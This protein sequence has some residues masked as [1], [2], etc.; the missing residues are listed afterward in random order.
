MTTTPFADTYETYFDRGWHVIPL[1]ARAK[2][3][4]PDGFTGAAAP[5]S[6]WPDLFTW[7]DTRPDANIA[8]RLP[9]TVIGVDVDAY[10]GKRG[11]ETIAEAEARWG[12]LPSTWT[13][14]SRTDGS[15][16]RLFTVPSGSR[17]RGELGDGV[18]IVQFSHRYVVAWPSIHPEGRTYRWITFDGGDAEGPPDIDDLPPLPQEWIDGLRTTVE[19]LDPVLA[20]GS[21]GLVAAALT[22]GQPSPNV[23]SRLQRA[24]ADLS[25]SA[26]SRFAATRGHILML[27]TLGHMGEPGVADAI[28]TLFHAYVPAVSAARQGGARAAESEFRRAVNR[29]GPRL[30]QPI[31]TGTSADNRPL[32]ELAGL[33][34]RGVD[35]KK[36]SESQVTQTHNPPPVAEDKPGSDRPR[37][38]LA[39]DLEPAKQPEWIGVRWLPKAA[40]TI[41]VGDE[42][43]GKSLFWVLVAAAVTTGRA[44]PACGI[45]AREPGIVLVVV[46]ED[47]WSTVVRPRLEVAG[48]DIER[49]RV[50]CTEK[51]GS[52]APVFPRDIHLIAEMPEA[53]TLIVVDAWLDTVPAGLKVSDPQGARQALHPWK[54]LATTTGAAT[55]LLTHTNRV[56]TANAR[57]RYGATSEL[58]KKARMTLYAQADDEGRLVVGPEKANST[59]PAAAGMFTIDSIQHFEPTEDDDGTVG[60]LR[61]VGASDQTARELLT[62]NYEAAVAFGDDPTPKMISEGWLRD[63]LAVEGPDAN[64]AELKAAAKRQGIPE[65]TIQRAAKAIGVVYGK[66]GFGKD[67][68]VT[69]SLPANMSA[70]EGVMRDGDANVVPLSRGAH[71]AHGAHAENPSSEASPHVRHMRAT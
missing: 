54:E 62:A 42:G 6:S 61:Y 35:D 3:P 12:A 30:A 50:I 18:E 48:A 45:P 19:P 27:L 69:W 32:F 11:A 10:G 67:A 37:V 46:T 2:T 23:A 66:S 64:G 8:I 5:M 59:K 55:M 71:G 40:T 28:T 44:L 21:G 4:P 49:I 39:A 53:P 57:D 22:G 33:P 70:D 14:T 52:G 13:S 58:R 29:A 20:A 25:G 26:G 47:D 15:G 38:W 31:S 63:Y 9:D 1:P 56:A 43:I 41:L 51:D 36:E 16:I 68:V 7:A 17:F 24:L 65:R 60:R 34:A